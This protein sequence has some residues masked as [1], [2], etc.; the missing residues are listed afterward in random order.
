MAAG[1]IAIVG[2]GLAGLAAG[3]E[4][5]AR[6][7]KVEVFERTRL[8]GGKATSF[9]LGDAEVDN[10]QHVFLNC[11]TE[12]IAFVERLGL[13]HQLE[14][15]ER[16][17]ALV[18]R[19][20]RRPAELRE[21][22]LPAPLH[23]LPSL[24]R[25]Q[26]LGWRD[27]V[28]LV[29]ALAKA[30]PSGA[31]AEE[32]FA[33]WLDR[34]R[35]GPSTRAGF[36]DLFLV[37]ALNAPLDRVSAQAALFVIRTAFLGGR[38]AARIGYC[39]VPLARIAEVAASRLDRVYLRTPVAGVLIEEGRAV[40]VRLASGHELGF[41]AMVL[42]VPPARLPALIGDPERADLEGVTGFFPQAIVDVH[43]WLRGARLGAPFAALLGSPVQWVF[44]KAPGYLCC[45]LSAAEG[46]AGWSENDLVALCRAEL[47]AV[48]PH[49]GR[50][51]LLRAAATRD[52]EATFVPA[53]GLRR[54]G[55]RTAVSNLALAG[56][57]TDTGWPATMES[58]VR[59]GVAAA[60]VIAGSEAQRVA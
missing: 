3:V 52:R 27:K 15:Q 34:H 20:G 47:E 28:R 7:F 36:W 29:R 9:S 42:A 10:G 35:Q 49:L 14:I 19:R 43:L 6:G 38:G 31:K 60:R 8:L 59:S 39:R 46:F 4:L 24:V 21:A 26:A 58:A 16:F 51:E 45:S 33:D 57:W 32:T 25:Y 1:R 40:G 18:L 12:F 13:A 5:K 54:P 30:N 11:C 23:L 44:E 37:P 41:D 56:A 55:A 48:L 2:A 53:P 22:R 17:R 50:T